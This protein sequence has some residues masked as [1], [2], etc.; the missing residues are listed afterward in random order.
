MKIVKLH[1]SGDSADGLTEAQLANMRAIY[2]D[3]VAYAEW[4]IR[5][6]LSR[7]APEAGL[8]AAMRKRVASIAAD[9]AKELQTSIAKRP[10][11]RWERAPARKLT[12]EE[13]V[14]LYSANPVKLS[15][16][17]LKPKESDDDV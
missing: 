7:P 9:L 3:P 14:A 11:D 8:M 13:L 6:G 17:A 12:P 2:E 5:M 10:R 4:R 15:A 1:R 16:A